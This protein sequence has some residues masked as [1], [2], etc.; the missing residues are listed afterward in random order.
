MKAAMGLLRR[1]TGLIDFMGTD[2]SA[3]Q[4]CDVARLGLGYVPE[5]RRIFTDLTVTENLLA[6]RQPQREGAPGWSLDEVFELFPHL[7]GL[8]RRRAGEMSGGE[9]Q[10]LA[11]ARIVEQMAQMILALKG[12]GA[13]VLLSEQNLHFACLVSDR[14]YVLEKG[15]IRYEGSMAALAGDDMLR[16][17][18]LEL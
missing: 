18:Y 3:S 2:I 10:M 14:A 8:R 5:D 12:R 1:R 9:Q 11:V 16:S 15:V 6:G 13:S 7:A 4:P 17:K